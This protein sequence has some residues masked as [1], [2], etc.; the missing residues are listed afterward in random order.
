MHDK[1]VRRRRAVLAALVVPRCS[2]SP[3][4]SANPPAAACTPSSAARSR[5]SPDP[6][7]RQPRAQARPRPVR[8]VR[9]HAGRQGRAR[10]AR[11]RAR[12]AA[13]QARRCSALRELEQPGRSSEIDTRGGLNQYDP[14]E[15]RV[16]GAPRAPG[17]RRVT[18]NKGSSDGVTV[19]DPVVN[20]QG[21]VGKVKSVSGG[22]AVVMLITDQD[23][24]VSARRRR[25]PAS[26]ASMPAVGAPGDLLFD[27]VD[28]PRRSAR[29]TSSSP[30]GTPR[31][32]LPSLLPA[33]DPD[34]H[35]QRIDIGDGDLDRRIHVTPAA[36]L[37]RLDIVAGADQAARRPAR[38]R[39][40]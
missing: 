7:G 23:F 17:T 19:D 26:R 24:G 11:G 20:G 18:I 40:P 10:Q 16:Y 12:P 6:G 27:L 13:Q 35:R 5:S 31:R 25:A 37:R 8:L 4:T 33:R 9:R 30:P 34:R 38:A 14:V 1:V 32:R 39:A 22:N 21:L 36:D 15:A 29:A 28:T 2:C 3:P